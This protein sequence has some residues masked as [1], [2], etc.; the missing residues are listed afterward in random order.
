MPDATD[1]PC[2]ECTAQLTAFQT[3]L[4]PEDDSSIVSEH[5]AA[6]ANCRLFSDQLDATVDFVQTLP[7]SDTAEEL[8]QALA[9]SIPPAVDTADPDQLLRSLCRVADRLDPGRAE[10]LVQRTFL[11]AIERDPQDLNLADLTRTLVDLAADPDPAIGSPV[12]HPP[13]WA[14]WTSNSIRSR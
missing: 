14:S 13:P 12:Y 4:L 7:L 8:S 9:D 5:L 1:L 6:C 10:D 11:T 3:G 2:V